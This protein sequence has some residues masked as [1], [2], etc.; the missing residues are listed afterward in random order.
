MLHFN[1]ILFGSAIFTLCESAA[2]F[3]KVNKKCSIRD[4]ECMQG[5]YR[6]MLQDIALNGVPELNLPRIDPL[7]LKNR[8]FVALGMVKVT[9]KEGEAKG[10]KDCYATS[11]KSDFD[12]HR[13][14]IDF[15]CDRFEIEGDYKIESTPALL[16]LSGGIDIHG[17]G[18]GGVVVE[19]V[20]LSFNFATE[21]KK[22]DDGEIHVLMKPEDSSYDFEVKGKVTVHA[23][24][25]L[26]GKQEISSVVVNIFNENWKFLTNT[27]GKSVVDQAMELFFKESQVFFEKYPAKHWV[28][29]DLSS[30]VS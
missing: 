29:D 18:K 16:A 26:V 9:M 14:A 21:F 1:V 22:L 17:E 12:N 30:Y 25:V 23:D 10:F 19:N 13:I 27:F 11:Y 8:E 2:I 15:V 28:T 7:S 20:H 3:E 6:I 4:D 5:I 24:N